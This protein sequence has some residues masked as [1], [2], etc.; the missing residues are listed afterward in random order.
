MESVD[1]ADK[2]RGILS[3]R[4]AA[5]SHNPKANSAMQHCIFIRAKRGHMCTIERRSINYISLSVVCQ[6]HIPDHV[7]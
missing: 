2:A 5:P 3:E 7:Q 1:I 4:T 6:C